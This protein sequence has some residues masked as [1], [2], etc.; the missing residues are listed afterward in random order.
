SDATSGLSRAV[1]DSPDLIL[2]DISLPAGDGLELA[3]K[4]RGLPE[5][6]STPIIFLTASR[7]PD[8]R[9]KAMDLAAAGLF[10]KPYDPDELLA[11]A[12]HALGETGMFRR[13]IARFS[14]SI[15]EILEQPRLSYSPKRV[16]IVEDDRRIATALS[17]RLRSAGYEVMV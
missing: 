3:R 10:D 16:L 8:L 14:K 6:R 13:P 2:L 15:E 12:G 5:T 1:Q 4:L 9:A 17:L 11:V 7:D